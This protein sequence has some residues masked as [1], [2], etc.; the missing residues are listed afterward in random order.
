[1]ISEI[2]CP[3]EMG[4]RCIQLV[5]PMDVL[6]SGTGDQSLQKIIYV[7]SGCIDNQHMKKQQKNKIPKPDGHRK[8]QKT[9]KGSR[10]NNASI[11][12][13]RRRRYMNFAKD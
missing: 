5:L 11:K 10:P 3:S 7:P 13:I 1:M 9:T 2:V 8:E 4:D 6:I 12:I